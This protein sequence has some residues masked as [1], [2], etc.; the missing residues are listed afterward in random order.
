MIKVKSACLHNLKNI[1]LEIPKNVF[2]VVTGVSGSGK[3]T[4]IFDIL[5]QEGKQAYLEAIGMAPVI[6]R[7]KHYESIEG[8]MPAIAVTQKT[9][10]ETNPRS[11]VGTRTGI[12][13]LLR[14]VY[15]RWGDITCAKCGTL[16][17]FPRMDREHTEEKNAGCNEIDENGLTEAGGKVCTDKN[18]FLKTEA[19]ELT[20]HTAN[21]VKCAA[22]GHTEKRLGSIHF[23]FN[24]VHGMCLHCSGRGYMDEIDVEKIIGD[25]DT[26]LSGICRKVG[27]NL[28]KERY[29]KFLKKYG[30][31][32]K[33]LFSQIP[34]E[35]R[36]IFLSGRPGVLKGVLSYLSGRPIYDRMQ[37]TVVHE[38]T[39]CH[40][41]RLRPEA[42][43]VSIAGRNITEMSM[44]TIKDIGVVLKQWLNGKHINP[45]KVILQRLQ[46]LEEAGLGHL[47]LYRPMPTLS[48][49]EAQ[50]LFLAS[51]LESEMGSVIY[52][53]DE[54]TSGLHEREKQ[55]MIN[56]LKALKENNNT[57]IAIEHDRNT[58]AAAEHI[59]DFGSLGG[60]AGGEIICSGS[61][62]DLLENERSIT[63]AYLKGTSTMPVRK[64]SSYSS[65][66]GQVISMRGVKTHNLKNIDVDIP[67]GL[68]VGIM[69]VSGSG[70]SSL[71]AD[72]LV[73]ALVQHFGQSGND[74]GEDD[75]STDNDFSISR[76]LY[77]SIDGFE[78]LSGFCEVV[79]KPIGRS[80]RSIPL[81]YAG[82]WDDIRKVF[83][84]QPVS[85]KAGFKPGHF[86]F[87]SEG[88][89]GGCRGMGSID[90]YM[91]ELGFMQITCPDCGGIRYSSEIL[92]VLYKGKSISDVLNMS[93]SDAVKLFANEGRI[94]FMLQTLER[95]G[96]GYLRC[97]QAVSTLSGGEAQRVKLAEELG[98]Q[99]KGN[100]LYILDEPTTGLSFHDTALLL[101]LLEQLRS[102]G[103]SILIIEHDPDVLNFCDYTI[104][105]GPGGRNEGG[106]VISCKPQPN[107]RS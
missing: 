74:E 75:A 52:I 17:T 89:C 45:V 91:G 21:K 60:D 90:K 39:F 81:S 38:C 11:V 76:P 93:I 24:S 61:M 19:D 44:L 54:P 29:E 41:M 4:A 106:E 46:Q 63:G 16:C 42:L 25:G 95:T 92:K 72:T 59:V 97:G 2:T 55:A 100:I 50:R 49:G 62:M 64:K 87:N 43:R 35:A 7:E 58:I 66:S 78:H 27:V 82:I 31:T 5:F 83:A 26:K 104:E 32:G 9:V 65:N 84:S 107:S 69:G 37:Y 48:G 86:S 94:A 73:P 101:A 34:R 3:S 77:S 105:L 103:N 36:D 71:I 1:D 98:R 96:L 85:K 88:A 8:L 53:F 51:H 23:S 33:S 14:D 18:V 15:S 68:I 99:R 22:C 13:N 40:G 30:I 47:S 6:E 57:V 12:S 102:Q 20:P 67:L 10:A 28:H 80:R 70:K 79:Q 56:K